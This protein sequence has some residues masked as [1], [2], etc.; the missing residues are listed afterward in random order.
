[1]KIKND[2]APIW[3]LQQQEMIAEGGET[4][5]QFLEYL[6]LW[7]NVAEL[8]YEEGNRSEGDAVSVKAIRACF[9]EAMA[10]PEE[11]LGRIDGT[12]L[13]PMLMYI[14]HAWEHGQEL[15]EQLSEIEI[16]IVESAIYEQQT[17]MQALA[18]QRAEAETVPTGDDAG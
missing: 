13:G 14:I 6:E 15:G 1:M 11:E 10:T 12:Y 4:A 3:S 8:I 7:C 16:K 17:K 2:V 18:E 5:K 9:L